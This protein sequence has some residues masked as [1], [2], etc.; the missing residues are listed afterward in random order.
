M[1]KLLAIMRREFIERVRTRWFIIGTV[2]VP[3]AF[4][5]FGYLPQMLIT[6]ETG[7]RRLVVLDATSAGMGTRVTQA[8]VAARRGE[9]ETAP[10]RYDVTR[11]PVQEDRLPA[12]RDSVVSLIGLRNGPEDAPDGVLV[13]TDSAVDGGHVS[14]LGANVTSVHD[15][16]QMEQVLRPVLQEERLRAAQASEAVI[17][18]AM[19]RLHVDAT[20]VT[21][22]RPTGQSAEA[23]F[24]LA[25]A[26]DLVMYITLLIYGIQVMNAVLEEKTNRIVEV[27]VSS[28]TPFQLLLGKVLGVGAAGLVQLAIW[29][30]TGFYLTSM[31]GHRSNP[32]GNQIAAG[33]AGQGLGAPAV[34]A[35]LVAV[36]LIF[37]L[38]GFFLYAGLYAA[39]G[40]MCNS[41]QETQQAQ[42]PVTMLI[43]LG[44]LAM[45]ALINE[46]SGTLARTLTFIPLFAPIVV[47][48]RYAIAPL[49]PAE[50]GLSIFT[51]IL[52]ILAVV[53]VAGRIYRVGILSYGKRPGIKELLRW[54]RA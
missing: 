12:V 39:V 18:A 19:V 13:L 22:G 1:N 23:S 29:S 41:T 8:L 14:Y 36:I 20:K 5:L 34:T 4:G 6:R 35:D 43:A 15:M 52:G 27:L 50:L 16:D 45:F 24:W 31:L 49:S 33:A 25:Y 54:V 30:G 2:L 11:L 3:L 44:M 47:P 28:V 10:P 48:V 38:L 37:F 51:T 26:V 9:A 17:H 21:E 32:M 53:W 42:P 40:A 46:P 7:T